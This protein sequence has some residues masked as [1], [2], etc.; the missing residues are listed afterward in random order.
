MKCLGANPQIFYQLGALG[1]NTEIIW[2]QVGINNV[3]LTAQLCKD[4]HT[5]YGDQIAE[6]FIFSLFEKDIR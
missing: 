6:E 5:P 4:M 1:V 2:D 3:F